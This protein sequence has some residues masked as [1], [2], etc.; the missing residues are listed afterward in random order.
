M[1]SRSARTTVAPAE[2][3]SGGRENEVVAVVRPEEIEVAAAREALRCGY[4]AQ[5]VVDSAMFT[6]ALE[7]LRAA[8]RGAARRH[9]C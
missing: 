1:A 5:G 4:L 6:G 7:R 8:A 2:R 9:R 3:A